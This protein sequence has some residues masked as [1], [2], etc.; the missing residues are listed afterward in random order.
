MEE[1]KVGF[2]L[3]EDDCKQ[4]CDLAEDY[5]RKR[6]QVWKETSQKI[7]DEKNSFYSLVALILTFILSISPLLDLSFFLDSNWGISSKYIFPLLIVLLSIILLKVKINYDK[8]IKE[9]IS[10]H[11]K[12]MHEMK[13]KYLS[14]HNGVITRREHISKLNYDLDNN[15]SSNDKENKT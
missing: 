15:P 7:Q 3:N 2:N 4:I 10:S 1:L 5:E 6:S 8:R 9:V 11:D 13:K 14:A 12:F